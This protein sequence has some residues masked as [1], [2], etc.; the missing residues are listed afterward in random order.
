M[1][2]GQKAK[3]EHHRSISGLKIQSRNLPSQYDSTCH[4]TPPQSEALSPVCSEDEVDLEDKNEFENLN[5]FDSLKVDFQQEGVE[6]WSDEDDEEAGG[7]MDELM[8]LHQEDL[9]EI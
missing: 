3:K 1:P 2:G 4:S 6:D 7:D 8:V 5:H 9:K